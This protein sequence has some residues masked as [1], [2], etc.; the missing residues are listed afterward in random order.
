[1]GRL[2]GY[3]PVSLLILHPLEEAYNDPTTICI[4]IWEDPYSTLPQNLQQGRGCLP[5]DH[6]LHTPAFRGGSPSC[7]LILL[8]QNAKNGQPW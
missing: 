3:S 7:P 5:R 4:D 8:S 6:T 1:M 2:L